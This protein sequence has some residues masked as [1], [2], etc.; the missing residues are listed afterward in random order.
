[1][2]VQV[3]ETRKGLMTDSVMFNKVN[4]LKSLLRS[5]HRMMQTSGTAEGLRNLIDS[6]LPK[7][8]K[9][10]Y[11]ASDKVGPVVF[12]QGTLVSRLC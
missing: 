1:M 5:I 10:I 6:E 3:S 7:S 2:T 9:R 12:G 8:L 11:Q 4:C